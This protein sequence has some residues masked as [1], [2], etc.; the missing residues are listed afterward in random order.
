MAIYTIEKYN[1]SKLQCAFAVCVCVP[2]STV[3]ALMASR[4][5][6]WVRKTVMFPMRAYAARCRAAAVHLAGDTARALAE[7]RPT[8]SVR[9]TCL[10]SVR[11]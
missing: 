5:A 2:R 6:L 4:P 9:K 1:D 8:S 7:S 3:S 10:F 11:A